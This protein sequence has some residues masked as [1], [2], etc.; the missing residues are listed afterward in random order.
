MALDRPGQP[1]TDT[2]TTAAGMFRHGTRPAVMR[3][4][5]IPPIGRR[6]VAEMLVPRGGIEPPTHGFSVRCSTN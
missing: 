5:L 1:L 6:K 4:G 3:T 2:P